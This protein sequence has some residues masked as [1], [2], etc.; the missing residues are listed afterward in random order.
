MSLGSLRIELLT[1]LASHAY[2]IPVGIETFGIANQMQI[3]QSA[4]LLYN[5]KRNPIVLQQE[6]WLPF[7]GG[8]FG[9]KSLSGGGRQNRACDQG[10]LQNGRKRA[11]IHEPPSSRDSA[12]SY[13]FPN[14]FSG[15][16]R[17]WTSFVPQ[18]ESRAQYTCRADVVKGSCYQRR[19]RP[20]RD[21]HSRTSVCPDAGPGTPT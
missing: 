2:R 1:K 18:P 19:A 12:A 11:S 14:E 6:R 10:D 8:S 20:S 7:V 13:R 5:R 3:R 9:S 16:L 21:S 15:K 4:A 17:V